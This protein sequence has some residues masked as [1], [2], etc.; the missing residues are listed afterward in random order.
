MQMAILKLSSRQQPILEKDISL[1]KVIGLV[2]LP[3]ITGTQPRSQWNKGEYRTH[4]PGVVV[5]PRATHDRVC[6]VGSLLA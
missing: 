5:C 3:G 1:Y 6:S 2:Q 4:L